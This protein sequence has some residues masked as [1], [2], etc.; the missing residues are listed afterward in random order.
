MYTLKTM[1]YWWRNLKSFSTLRLEELMLLKYPYSPK[2]STDV[3]Q[4][5]SKYP[6]YFSHKC[7]RIILKL[8]WNDKRPWIVK[9]ILRKKEQSWTYNTLRLLNVLLSYSN[10]NSMVLA[11][12]TDV[13]QWKR[14][15]RPEIWSINL[16][17]RRQEYTTEKRPSLQEVV[18]G[19]P[20]SY[21]FIN[22]FRTFP[23]SIYKINSKWIKDLN[24]K[25]KVIKL[26]EENIS[27]T[28]WHKL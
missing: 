7:K 8:V 9:A 28:L 26:L 5:L 24:V 20:D 2:L 21:M 22:E 23:Y 6:E 11:Q 1:K 10:Q 25:P 3:M 17:K 12:K 15:E 16:W 27:R 18:L 19:K 13:A 14:R 4:S